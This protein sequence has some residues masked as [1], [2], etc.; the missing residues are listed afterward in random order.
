MNSH[1]ANDV[2]NI[3]VKIQTDFLNF[4]INI[5]NDTLFTEFGKNQYNFK[6]IS[7]AIKKM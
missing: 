7:Y 2:D 6:K 5:S 1:A 4:I 3:L